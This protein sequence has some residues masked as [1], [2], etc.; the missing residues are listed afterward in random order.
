MSIAQTAQIETLKPCINFEEL[1]IP[2]DSDNPSGENLQYAGLYDEIREARRSEDIEEQ[3]DWKREAKIADWYKV[4]ALSI[5][6]LQ[7]KTKD[8]Q[9]AVWL[10]EALVKNYSFVGL[11][12][13]LQ[14][15]KRLLEN[16]WDTIFPE[17]EDGDLEARANAFSWF[18]RQISILLK[19]LPIT[20]S[21]LTDNYSYLQYEESKFFDIP[22]KTDSLSSEELRHIDELKEQASK[23]NKITS[24][25]WRKAQNT[26]SI[27]FY[28]T[29]YNLLNDCWQAYLD[30]D[31]LMDERFASQTP[32][33]GVLKKSL[34]DIRS[35]IEKIYKGKQPIVATT[36]TSPPNST[37]PNLTELTEKMEKSSPTEQLYTT[38]FAAATGVIRSR[39]DALQR[40]KEVAEYF[41][42][43]EPHS[44]V[45]FLIE[46][47]IKWGE[48]PLD[49]WLEEVI[50]NNEIL[51]QVRETLG[52]KS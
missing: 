5:N 27:S 13:S 19:Q 9:I 48:M 1:L 36:N 17:N 26:S 4:I 12:D 11:R 30:L 35:L 37:S 6:A 46:R 51:G 44:P 39:G 49:Q 29:N 25:K 28:Q 45:A 40:L 52:I 41:H 38:V 14:L 16:F 23:E 43:T 7:T 47:A 34:E 31:K 2:I 15:L 22:E 8:L 33:L 20:A 24:E 21:N 10:S 50:K 42:K 32:G 3:G 18:D